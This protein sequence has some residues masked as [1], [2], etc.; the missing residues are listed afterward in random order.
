MT[1]SA[2]QLDYSIA[3]VP[4]TSLGANPA[5]RKYSS[6]TTAKIPDVGENRDYDL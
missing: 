1:A 3:A 5:T 4:E 6:R 2:L